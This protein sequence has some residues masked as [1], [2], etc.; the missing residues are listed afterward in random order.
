M[1]LTVTIHRRALQR[2]GA[3]EEGLALFDAIKGCAD[4]ERAAAGKPARKG[5]VVRWTRVHAIWM[6]TVYPAFSRWLN[7]HDL[8]P[9]I[10]LTCADLTC[11][12][13]TRANLTRA[14]LYGADLTRANLTGADLT[15]ADLTRANLTGAN[16]YGADL[17]G[18]DLY[19]ANLYGANLYG[20]NLTRAKIAT[21]AKVPE[22]WERVAMS[23]SCCVSLR[24]RDL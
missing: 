10:N 22:G 7:D 15:R 21:D 5:L 11:A 23:C 8:I 17:Y 16:L 14:N 12:D 6:A 1:G 9:A 4:G 13:L 2:H 24:R 20:A 3:C 19:G 18:A